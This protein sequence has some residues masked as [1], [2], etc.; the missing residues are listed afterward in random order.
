MKKKLR[1]GMIGYGFMGKAHTNAFRQAAKFFPEDKELFSLKKLAV[2]GEANINRANLISKDGLNFFNKGL[3][4]EAAIKFETA[5]LIDSLEYAHFENAASAYYMGGDYAK[6]LIYS[7]KVIN[8]FQIKT[9][10]SEYICALTN[11]N[12]GGN[13]RA[14]E[15][16]QKSIN[17]GAVPANKDL[18]VSNEI[19]FIVNAATQAEI[20][21]PL[22]SETFYGTG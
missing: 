6:A 14:C 17:Y 3:Y 5:A 1:V 19:F 8:N 21:H 13:S 11:F 15:L 4:T 10:K 16:L 2:I 20:A 12:I 9:G 22:E 7:E 18:L